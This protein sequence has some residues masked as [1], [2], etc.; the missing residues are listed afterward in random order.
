MRSHFAMTIVAASR[1]SLVPLL[2]IMGASCEN[3]DPKTSLVATPRGQLAALPATDHVDG[4]AREPMLLETRD[5]TLYVTGYGGPTPR[6]WRSV[7]AGRSW[8]NVNVGTEA[9]GA[10]G[11][12]DVDLAMAPDGT[13]YFVVM[14]YDRV[15]Y[16]GTGISIAASRDDGATWKWTA[17]SRDRF[18]DRPWVEVAPDGVA[19]VIW[20]D[21]A[22]ISHAV[23]PDRGQT[24]VER[25]R[26]HTAGGSSHFAISPSGFLAVRITPLSA[27]ANKFDPGVDHVAVSAD[28]GATWTVRN[29]PGNRVWSVP[30][31][32]KDFL[33]WVEPVAWD[34]TDHLYALWSE[35]TT[36]RL[37]Q[38]ADR[39]ASWES[40]EVARD[41]VPI[42][43]PYL[44]AREQGELAATWFTGLRDSIRAN[45][46]HI[47]VSSGGSP[48]VTNAES[49]AFPAFT[50]ADSTA[51]WIRDTAG[52]YI[53]VVFLRDGRIVVVT[54]IQDT[55]RQAR[56]FTF[57]PYRL[58]LGR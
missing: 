37:G 28:G 47:R 41:S 18:D 10:I 50:R 56:G 46:A 5:G 35:G 34:A 22:G 31:V 27:S 19:H 44:I 6:L 4:L 13:L 15:K 42:Y 11:N 45:L 23:S 26:I 16:E 20:N 32:N 12:S 8:S 9:D 54:T 1:F 36:L 3:T 48:H 55:P 29:L 7:D 49:F 17:I 43:F 2:V 24:W 38:S 53:P 39:G 51:A 14:S 58:T 30:E 40:W 25:P 21:G 33:R 52:E 57:R